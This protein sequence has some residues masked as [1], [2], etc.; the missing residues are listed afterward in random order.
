MAACVSWL[1]LVP[2]AMAKPLRVPG[3]L[4]PPPTERVAKPP[5]GRDQAGS[6]G[7]VAV[8]LGRWEGH[9]GRATV[10]LTVEETAGGQRYVVRPVVW[11]SATQASYWDTDPLV[12]GLPDAWPISGGGTLLGDPA[13]WLAPP[14]HGRFTATAATLTFRDTT[15]GGH[16]LRVVARPVPTWPAV[17]DAEWNV[18]LAPHARGFVG[19]VEEMQ[20]IGQGALVN[21]AAG[22]Y[23]GPNCL[24]YNSGLWVLVQPDGSFAATG[25]ST[26]IGDAGVTLHLQG[27]FLSA[28]EAQGSYT[29]T[30]PSCL[31]QPVRFSAHVSSLAVAPK[32]AAGS[33]TLHTSPSSGPTWLEQLAEGLKGVNW[34]ERT[35]NFQRGWVIP[36]GLSRSDSYKIVY[37]KAEAILKG[38]R[39]EGANTVR[40][41]I[42]LP[43]VLD[44]KPS[45]WPRY[46]GAIN[47]ALALHM[48]V[49]LSYWDSSNSGTIDDP[50]LGP[51]GPLLRGLIGPPLTNLNDYVGFDKM[52]QKVLTDYGNQSNVF[53][54]IMNEPDGYSGRQWDSLAD[55]WVSK[56]LSE[57]P[58][59]PADRI[60]VSAAR[61]SSA[62]RK[63][64]GGMQN[65]LSLVG[66]DPKLAGTLLSV[67]YYNWCG[68]FNDAGLF[69]QLV[70]PYIGHGVVIDE[71]GTTVV[72]KK[73]VPVNFSRP[74][75]NES[76][77]C[78]N[79]NQLSSDKNISYMQELTC[80]LHAGFGAVYWP[81]LRATDRYSVWNL[82]SAP[83]WWE[84]STDPLTLNGDG[85]ILPLLQYAWT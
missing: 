25:A 69:D 50:K 68:G 34:A 75:I 83:N 32:L 6:P 44:E 80:Y 24:F 54:E 85:S 19:E 39:T 36:T 55:Q 23:D 60:I 77:R 74:S 3:H 45:W 29:L 43:T 73:G 35:D 41:P 5:T 46:R 52:W 58:D 79:K 76:Q 16:H 31:G 28:S 27:R 82:S 4:T 10:L 30:G 42:N 72:T 51:L 78:S 81:G 33:G 59:V 64:L 63:C 2:P 21:F 22:V 8:R 15:C 56:F 84:H 61:N 13:D 17:P 71:F 9:S 18:S 40:L 57:F 26:G 14:L 53:F 37:A 11:C 49:I 62:P 1:L 48:K 20:T 47:A 67:H 70:A 66:N 12:F 7:S 65:D 38:F